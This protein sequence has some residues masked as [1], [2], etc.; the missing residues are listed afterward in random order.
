M[1]SGRFKLFRAMANA[2]YAIADINDLCEQ[3]TIAEI[4]FSVQTGI[5][6]AQ[7]RLPKSYEEIVNIEGCIY[8]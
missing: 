2:V 1:L 3:E 8:D 7:K 6:K 5:A 4:N